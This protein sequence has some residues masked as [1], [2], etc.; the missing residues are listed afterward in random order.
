M[1]ASGAI[2]CGVPLESEAGHFHF[3]GQWAPVTT[4]RQEWQ[5]VSPLIGDR[6]RSMGGWT[7][8]EFGQPDKH[9]IHHSSSASA[10][11]EVRTVRPALVSSQIGYSSPP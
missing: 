7:A 10:L 3:P 8:F 5:A 6:V 4:Y 2:L 11:M 1:G 9:W